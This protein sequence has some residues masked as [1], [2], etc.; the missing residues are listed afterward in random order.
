MHL[1]TEEEIAERELI[2]SCFHEVSHGVIAD[3]FG[4]F[5]EAFVWSND[6]QEP[7]GEKAWLGRCQM[8]ELN[9]TLTDH[10]PRMIGMAGFLAEEIGLAK[11]DGDSENAYLAEVLANLS[12]PDYFDSISQSDR[13][14]IGEDFVEQDVQDALRLV[15]ANWRKID[16][17]ANKLMILVIATGEDGD[18]SASLAISA[19]S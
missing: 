13:R 11:I 3:H 7:T 15:L 2:R 14:Q 10:S 6:N 1:R 16:E 18:P 17:Q 9:G 8:V 12:D 4:V 19:G 5:A